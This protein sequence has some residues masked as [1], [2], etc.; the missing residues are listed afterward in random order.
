MQEI[1]ANTKRQNFL[2]QPLIP[3]QY[4]LLIPFILPLL[5]GQTKLMYA[6]MNRAHIFKMSFIVVKA[7]LKR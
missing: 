6:E 3:Y 2:P 1:L 5:S 4:F 7:S